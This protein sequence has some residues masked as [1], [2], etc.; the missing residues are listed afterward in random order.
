MIFQRRLL[1][2]FVATES[3]GIHDSAESAYR[4]WSCLSR[5]FTPGSLTSG[6]SRSDFLIDPLHA[7]QDRRGHFH[8]FAGFSAY[9]KFLALA[10]SK[11]KSQASILCYSDLDDPDAEI[12]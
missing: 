4:L 6:I 5:Q 8:V 3:I 9:Q 10:P 7:V 1:T 11:K 2:P 12:I